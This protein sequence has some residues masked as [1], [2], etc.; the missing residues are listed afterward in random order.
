MI[1]YNH[2]FAED[3][4]IVNYIKKPL[5]VW[6]YDTFCAAGQEINAS[7]AGMEMQSFPDTRV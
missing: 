1:Y 4:T 2:H 5:Y 6:Y 7:V 3:N